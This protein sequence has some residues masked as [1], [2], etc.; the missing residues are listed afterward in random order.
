MRILRRDVR[1]VG[2]TVEALGPLHREAYKG[3]LSKRLG[4]ASLLT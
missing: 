2:E 4:I 3:I 1:R